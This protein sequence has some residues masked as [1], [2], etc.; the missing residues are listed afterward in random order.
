MIVP[1]VV[2][3]DT[4]SPGGLDNQFG[5]ILVIGLSLRVNSNAIHLCLADRC[6][7]R[8]TYNPRATLVPCAFSSDNFP[9]FC[10]AGFVSDASQLANQPAPSDLF[11]LVRHLAAVTRKRSVNANIRK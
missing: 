7:N 1:V 6:C 11:F 9:N 3:R 10:A 2:R 8:M 4:I 5:C